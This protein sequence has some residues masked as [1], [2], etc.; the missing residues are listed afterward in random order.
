MMKRK[1]VFFYWIETG[2]ERD[3]FEKD[4]FSDTIDDALKKFR[5]TNPLNKIDS[6]IK[7][8]IYE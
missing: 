8:E 3:W 1:F 6:I 5:E 7:K 4:V 2:D